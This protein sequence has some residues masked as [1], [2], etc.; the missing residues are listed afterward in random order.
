[1]D[2]AREPKKSWE[3]ARDC[4]RVARCPAIRGHARDARPGIA[5]RC[6][7]GRV[8]MH[9]K[10]FQAGLAVAALL[11]LGLCLSPALAAV[12]PV[13]GSGVM[14]VTSAQPVEDGVFVEFSLTGR[15]NLIGQ[16]TGAAQ[17]LF[18]NAGTAFTEGDTVLVARNGD[19]LYLT[20]HG[21]IAADGS[22]SAIC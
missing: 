22:L 21:T 12:K 4:V 9:R 3:I 19:E 1:H 5:S 13:G 16:F 11:A 2:P 10:S 17:G 8:T 14:V 18:N 6:T 15:G 20:C 7:E